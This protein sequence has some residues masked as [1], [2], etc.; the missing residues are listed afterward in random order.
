[1]SLAVRRSQHR[2]GNAACEFAILVP[3]LLMLLLGMWEVGRLIQVK[4]ILANAA[5]EGARQAATGRSTNSDVQTVVCQYLKDAGLPDY[6]SQA[7]S[8]VTVTD[9][10]SGGDVSDA[11]QGDQIRVTVSIPFNDV[12]WVALYLIT[13]ANTRLNAEADWVCL[14]DQN[15]PSSITSPDGF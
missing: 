4:Q 2:N 6:T 15:Y 7:S 1:M 11:S 5:R 13:S 14:M 10:T 8:V 9:V 3:F 12:R